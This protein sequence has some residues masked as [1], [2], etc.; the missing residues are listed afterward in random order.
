MTTKQ[1]QQFRKLELTKA[2]AVVDQIAAEKGIPSLTY[3]SPPATSADVVPIPSAPSTLAEA[4][5]AENAKTTPVSL[6]KPLK[7]AKP[8]K[9][10]MEDE[11]GAAAMQ[12]LTIDLPSYLFKEIAQ[13]GFDQNASAKY[14]ILQ[15]LQNDRFTI[16]PEDMKK[17]GRRAKKETRHAA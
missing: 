15:A 14:V 12:R 7:P 4:E 1:S 10:S 9:L 11:E 6:A 8:K 13:R 17:D 2:F 16:K 5:A 3:P